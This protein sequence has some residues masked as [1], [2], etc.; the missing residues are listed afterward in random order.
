VIVV[1]DTTPLNYLVLINA[2]DVLHAL[3][4][5]VHAPPAV[6]QELTHS[7]A[8]DAVRKW[9]LALPGWLR[10]ST[11]T[12]RLPSTAALDAGEAEA[13]S[14]AKELGVRDIL[15]DERR[16]RNIATR[17]GLFVLPTLAIIELAAEEKL[18]DLSSTLE[19]LRRTTF[20]MPQERIEAMLRRDQQRKQSDAGDPPG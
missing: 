1:A 10:V 17:E 19:A 5:E 13:I 4:T 12:S 18:L 14:L 8:P 6:I 15:I 9:A 20:R 3:F 16:G 11:P 7:S 2:I